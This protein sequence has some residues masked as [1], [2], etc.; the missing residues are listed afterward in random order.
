MIKPKRLGKVINPFLYF[1]RALA[2]AIP[3]LRP[4]EREFGQIS[5]SPLVGSVYPTG[6]AT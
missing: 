4:T 5:D 3:M 6:E 2:G 1:I